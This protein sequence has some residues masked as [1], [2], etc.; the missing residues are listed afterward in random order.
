MSKQLRLLAIIPAFNESAHL[1]DVVRQA[2]LSASSVLVVDDGS[3][4]GTALAA[5]RAGAEVIIHSKNV[6][7]GKALETGFR[8]ALEGDC[9]AVVTLDA[10]GQH[11]PS[12]IE[13]L[14]KTFERTNADI[15]IGSRMGSL[16]NMPLVRRF[17]NRVTSGIISHLAHQKV[18][19]SQSGFRLIRRRVLESTEMRTGHFDAESEFLVESSRMGFRF[20]E[21]PISTIYAD[22]KSKIH[23]VLDTLRFLRLAVR[24]ALRGLVSG[25][26]RAES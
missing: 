3:G 22:E 12:E 1:A 6:G 16:A 17:T 15:V 20:A 2:R 13:G 10:D 23:P 18:S 4:D 19:D 25:R 11:R 5:R 24:L 21:S 8:T 7:K 26:K 9:Q 14:L